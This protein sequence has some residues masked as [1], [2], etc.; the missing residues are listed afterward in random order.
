MPL[1]RVMITALH[2]V[3]DH[4]SNLLSNMYLYDSIGPF[5][6]PRRESI[7]HTLGGAQFQSPSL[8]AAKALSLIHI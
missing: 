5:W 2:V 3:G 6:D 8:L 1:G 7:L 4:R